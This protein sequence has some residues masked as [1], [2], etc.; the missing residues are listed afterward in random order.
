MLFLLCILFSVINC[1]NTTIP[2]SFSVTY[3]KYLTYDWEIKTCGEAGTFNI[4]KNNQTYL[5]LPIKECDADHSLYCTQ[6]FSLPWCVFSYNPNDKYEWYVVNAGCNQTVNKSTFSTKSFA[7]YYATNNINSYSAKVY[8]KKY[9]LV[10]IPHFTN[11][12]EPSCMAIKLRATVYRSDKYKPSIKIHNDVNTCGYDIISNNYYISD[13][14][15]YETNG[16]WSNGYASNMTIGCMYPSQIGPFDI[17]LGKKYI[18]EFD[19]DDWGRNMDI[20]L[21]I[22]S[23]EHSNPYQL[24]TLI[25]GSIFIGVIGI[26]ALTGSIILYIKCCCNK[27]SYEVINDDLHEDL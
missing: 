18:I 25:L 11:T 8:Y 1:G 16:Y 5:T 23:R 14:L 19:A 7:V 12:L 22:N 2:K 27:P 21:Q 17:A 26:I 4:L 10:E 15:P 9:A 20:S 24:A 6:S 13:L 3:E